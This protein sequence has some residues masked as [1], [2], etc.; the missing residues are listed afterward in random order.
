MLY[1]MLYHMLLNMLWVS[2]SAFCPRWT[3]KCQVF[4]LQAS[5]LCKISPRRRS[6][7]PL[8]SRI[9]YKRCC[10]TL[11]LILTKWI[12]IGTSGSWAQYRK[13]TF[14]SLISRKM[15]TGSK[16]SG[17]SRDQLARCLGQAWQEMWMSSEIWCYKACY[18]PHHILVL[19]FRGKYKVFSM[20][21]S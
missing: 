4:S 6:L 13:V 8:L 7:M 1:C 14:K 20:L 2:S 21:E 12:T 3:G 17:C 11:T 10:T 9:S 19:K 5:E 15:V 18:I 16:T